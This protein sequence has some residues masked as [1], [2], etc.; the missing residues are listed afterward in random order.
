MSSRLY[1][2]VEPGGLEESRF[3]AST[4]TTKESNTPTTILTTMY[5]LRILNLLS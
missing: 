3:P 4:T 1:E 5:L 2:L